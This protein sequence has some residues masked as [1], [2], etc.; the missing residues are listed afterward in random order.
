MHHLCF[1]DEEICAELN[2]AAVFHP[3]TGPDDDGLPCVEVA[4]IPV[5]AYVDADRQTVQVSVHF[6]TAEDR[7]VRPDG[8]VPLRVRVGDTVVLNDSAQG[9]AERELL[10]RLLEA[11]DDR[12][13]QAI[14]EAAFA[15]GVLR[16]H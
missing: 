7:L 12:Q 15:A 11:A 8:T 1:Q 13:K 2:S 5:F 16:H 6:D 4:G 14:R 3:Q 9:T 10:T